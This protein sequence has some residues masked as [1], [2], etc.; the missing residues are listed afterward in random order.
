MRLA[1][2]LGME[3]EWCV[4][5]VVVVVAVVPGV[6]VGAHGVLVLVWALVRV[7]CEMRP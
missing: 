1:G 7:D 2:E 6:G 5:D 4:P 3:E